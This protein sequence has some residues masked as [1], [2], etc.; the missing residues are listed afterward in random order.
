MP[1]VINDQPI[2]EEKTLLQE[3]ENP[4]DDFIKAIGKQVYDGILTQNVK[5][6]FGTI[7]SVAVTEI[8]NER[9]NKTLNDA[10]ANNET[11]QEDNNNVEDAE[12]YLDEE[13]V[14][15]T[16]VEKEGYFIVRSIASEV[17]DSNRVA[18]R[19]RKHY[20]NILFD[21]NQRYPIVRFYFNNENH[22]RVEFYDEITLTSNGGKKGEKVDINEVSDLYNYKERILK[23]VNEYLEM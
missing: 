8:I 2:A 4:S 12:E 15:T 5:E 17:I 6:R 7:I 22:L 14:I 11:Q 13:G 20:C 19:D 23:V 1:S 3:F 9:I 10:V 21:N 18:I 16:D